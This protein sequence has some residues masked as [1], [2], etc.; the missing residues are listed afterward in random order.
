MRR[1][2]HARLH[3]AGHAIDVAVAQ[4]GHSH[5]KATKGYHFADGPY[6]EYEGAVADAAAFVRDVNT[7]LAALVQEGIDTQAS[8]GRG[9]RGEEG[10]RV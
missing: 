5:L 4:A 10:R 3:S 9:C 2:L 8:A 6:V 7:R 1:R